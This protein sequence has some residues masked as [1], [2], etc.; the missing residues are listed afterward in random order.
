MQHIITIIIYKARNFCLI[1][2]KQQL[3]TATTTTKKR[4]KFNK[5]KIVYLY[6]YIFINKYIF[7]CRF[8]CIYIF[9]HVRSMS[10]WPKTTWFALRLTLRLRWKFIQFKKAKKQI[11]MHLNKFMHIFYVAVAAASVC[12]KFFVVL[13]H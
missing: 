8:F 9:L 11:K 3:K 5:F 12:Y 4:K 2:L 6:I 1:A 7:C 10:H 13:K